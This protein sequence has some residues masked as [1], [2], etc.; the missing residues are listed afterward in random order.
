MKI[1]A[2][3]LKNLASLAGEQQIDFTAE[4]L[5]SAGLFA[6]TGPTGAGK[7]TLLDALCLALFGSTP[8]LDKPIGL[9]KVPDGKDEIATSDERNLLRRGCGNAY[10][11]VDFI[12]IDGHR[13]R[14]R[15]EANRARERADGRLQQSRQTLIDLDHNQLLA[16]GKKREF[17]SLLEERLGLNLAQFTHAVLLAQSEF[18]AFLKADDNE[19]GALLEKLTDTGLYSRLGQAAFAAAKVA[20]EDLAG[21]ERQFGNT[22]PLAADA[23]QELE[24]QHHQLRHELENRQQTLQSL[25]KRQH[26]LQERSRLQRNVETAMGQLTQA[27]AEHQA[28]AETRQTLALLEE[29]APQR[30]R[31]ARLAE[32]EPRLSEQSALMARQ[33]QQQSDLQQHLLALD[34]C[35][36]QARTALAT[37]E[38]TRQQATPR[39]E[40]A[41]EEEQLQTHL[42]AEFEQIRQNTETAQ[43]ATAAGKARLDNVQ[44][45]QQ[46]TTRQL[47]RLAAEL[48]HDS[49]LQALCENWTIQRPRLLQLEQ[50]ALR[51]RQNQADLPALEQAVAQ[52]EAR[53]VTARQALNTLQVEQGDTSRPGEQ[54]ETLQRQL[55]DWRCHQRDGETLQRLW[56]DYQAQRQRLRHQQTE[57]TARQTELAT[58]SETGRQVRTEHDTARQ[59]LEVILQLLERQRLARSQSVT[60]LRAALQPDEP[61][62]VCGSQEHPWHIQD[63]LLAALNKQ[64]EQEAEQAKSRL[65]KLDQRLQALRERHVELNTHIKQLQQRYEETSH[66]VQHLEKALLAMPAYAALLELPDAERSESLARSVNELAERIAM[67]AQRQRQ[68]ID[69][70]QRREQLQHDLQNA[71]E[72]CLEAVH[73]RDRQ[74]QAVMHDNRQFEQELDSLAPLLPPDSLQAWRDQPNLAFAPLDTAVTARRQQLERQATLQQARLEYE[75]ALEREHYEQTARLNRQQ[76]CERQQHEQQSRLLDCRQRLQALLGEFPHTGAWQQQLEANLQAARDTLA[77]TE[78]QHHENNRQLA[79][80]ANELQTRQKRLDELRDEQTALITELDQWRSRHP[81]LDDATLNM[82][83]DRPEEQVVA[84]RET[85]TRN[86]DAL[87]QCRTTLEER[88]QRLAAHGI[89]PQPLIDPAGLEQAIG[90]NR[91]RCEEIEHQCTDRRA[92][93]L[94]DDRRRQHSHDLLQRIDQAQAEY[95]RRERINIL[96]GSADGAAFRKIAQ[97]HNLDLLVQHANVQLRHLARRYR[98]IRGGSPLGLLVMDTEMGDELRSVHSLSGGETFL[99]SLALALGLASMASSKLRIESLFIDEGFGSLDPQSLQIA[100]DALDSLQAQGRKVAVISHVQELHERIPVQIQVQRLGNGRSSLTIKG[101]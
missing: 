8:R 12:G 41:R 95:R 39:L 71:N 24:A 58:L 5:A 90:E 60:Q 92:T 38:Q 73:L 83:L 29:L 11:E 56:Q 18:S 19:R 25:E 31:F 98:L 82:L 16:S 63:T 9:S 52:A 76:D 20:R 32:L 101:G 100:M 57:Q 62:P 13:Y 49:R 40:Q 30:H 27:E 89:E 74:K 36:N 88:R 69:L 91:L 81:Q 80:V 28:L 10:A 42:S 59:A 6:I 79:V 14:A 78:H 7:S 87:T 64:D 1:L 61:C 75:R 54:L 43:D 2:I 15:W 4:P 68:L 47:D 46:A 67:A 23:R 51:L 96:I 22:Q 37:A 70:Q 53:Q 94:D 72:L 35:C 48:T 21:L 65:T 93:L 33:Q 45:Q 66:A 17:Q 84:L 26:W 55:D 50:I 85:L 44:A 77:Q 97:A 99:V 86:R 3:R 34:T